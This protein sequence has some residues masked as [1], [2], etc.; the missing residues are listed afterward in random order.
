MPISN[1]SFLMSI[2]CL[3]ASVKATCFAFVNMFDLGIAGGS[4]LLPSVY[5]SSG[6]GYSS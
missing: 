2:W 5:Y 4:E 3:C 6:E 1:I